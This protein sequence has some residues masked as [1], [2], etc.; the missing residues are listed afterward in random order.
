MAWSKFT[1]VL[2]LWV[3][4]GINQ[5]PRWWAEDFDMNRFAHELDNPEARLAD[6]EYAVSSGDNSQAIKHLTSLYIEALERFDMD[7]IEEYTNALIK[8]S[9][10]KTPAGAD[11][12]NWESQKK[13][14]TLY[15]TA[16]DALTIDST[17]SQD[18]VS[19]ALRSKSGC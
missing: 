3:F 15:K 2:M 10:E 17:D 6:L 9:M 8:H 13:Y 7:E 12:V 18:V 14:F 5:D 16:M 11:S 1:R 4:K 19:D